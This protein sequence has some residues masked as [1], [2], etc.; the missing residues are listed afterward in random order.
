MLFCG[1]EYLKL[2]EGSYRYHDLDAAYI[3]HLRTELEN[4]NEQRILMEAGHRL[5]WDRCCE[6]IS[7]QF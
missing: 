3:E 1:K 2:F 4:L 7:R 6:W 5:C